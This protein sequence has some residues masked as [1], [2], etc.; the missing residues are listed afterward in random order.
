MDGVLVGWMTIASGL[1]FVVV[2]VMIVV[3]KTVLD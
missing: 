3:A 1:A 2:V